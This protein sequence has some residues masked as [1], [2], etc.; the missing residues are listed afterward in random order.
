M[1]SK[2][3]FLFIKEKYGDVASWAVW[4]EVGEKPKSNM[5]YKNIFDLEKNP[6]ILNALRND[7][8]MV[9]LNLSNRSYT[10]RWYQ[11]FHPDYST[12]QDY[13]IRFA[14]KDT[15]Y[16]GAYMTDV[17]KSEV[18]LSAKKVRAYLR[19]NPAVIKKN[20]ASLQEELQDIRADNPVILAF[21]VDAYEIL[22][23]HYPRDGYSK[24]VKLIHY[25]HYISK[26]QY[27]DEVYKALGIG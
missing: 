2:E 6:D 19:D 25:S 15:I 27:R 26:E 24:L 17:I 13:K 7:V 3:L 11:N 21:G 22:K 20:I 4:E 9:G 14:F 8:V 1:I 18:N 12:A 5:G 16:Y 23:M 10:D